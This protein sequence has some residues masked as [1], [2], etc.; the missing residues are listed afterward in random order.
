MSEF[1]GS[2]RLQKGAIISISRE[3]P[4]ARSIR[5][6]Y[7]P[8]SVKRVLAPNAAA[9]SGGGG[10][11]SS[12]EGSKE[13]HKLHGPPVET[14]SLSLHFDASDRLES[15]DVTA[16][17]LGIY[18]ELSALETLLYPKT[19]LMFARFLL[20]DS[21]SEVNEP[22]EMAVTLFYWGPGRIQPVRITSITIDETNFDTMLNPIQAEVSISM[23]TLGYDDLD[24]DS[25]AYQIYLAYQRIKEGRATLNGVQTVLSAIK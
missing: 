3:N 9:R 21:G 25:P 8:V 7:N 13:S 19:D 16:V 12:Q 10:A 24:K 6:Q 1:P 15:G 17:S 22:L 4:L 5:F 18:P 11:G 20:E 2:P 23:E 14:I